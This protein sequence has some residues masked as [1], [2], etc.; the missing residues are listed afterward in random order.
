VDERAEIEEA[1]GAALSGMGLRG[2]IAVAGNAIEWS[3]DGPPI[4][5]DVDVVLRQ[6][7]LLPAEM[8][9]RK[10][11]EIARRLVDAQR[12]AGP[13]VRARRASPGAPPARFW[14]WGAAGIGALALVG[15]VRMA[16]PRLAGDTPPPNGVPSEAETA[17]R[18]RLSRACV[19][20]RDRL[21]KGA[22]FG[23]LATE[24]WAVELWLGSRKG[25]SL[26][27]QA[28]L[29]GAVAGG[30][31]TAAGDPELA[32]VTDGAAEIVD[33][34]TDEMGKRSPAWGGATLVLREGYARA[35]LEEQ[36]RPRFV[37]MAR[38]L[39]DAA[40]ADAG[41]LYARCAHQTTHDIGAWF[42]G[43]DTPTAM[44]AMIYQMG[45]FAEGKLVD[46]AALAAHG[47][48][49]GDLDALARA[50]KDAGADAL[51]SAVTAQ[52]GSVSTAHGV[53][54]VFP[55]SAPMRAISATRDAA[56]KMGVGVGTD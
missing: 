13:A 40:G 30:K 45:F 27:D 49:G 36:T 24:G 29:Q 18:D 1:V 51:T 22:S 50:A 10:V 33:G 53:S 32:A 26:R 4:A 15:V 9:Q 46:R 43:A 42:H 39:A 28:A 8:K 31:L 11:G 7:P 17:R 3:T 41:A 21:Y 12:A 14:I 38:R 52:G 25:A 48:A 54:L 37:V 20:M 55:L 16:L 44:A 34:F 35:F 6:W 2:T 5:I 23:P 47:A 56:R 19:A